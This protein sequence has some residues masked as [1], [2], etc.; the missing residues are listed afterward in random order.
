MN[1][2]ETTRLLTWSHVGLR[3]LYGI[4]MCILVVWSTFTLVPGFSTGLFHVSF[5][6]ATE[7][8]YLWICGMSL[9][10]GVAYV[11]NARLD[12]ERNIIMSGLC[13]FCAVLVIGKEITQ[14]VFASI[15]LSQN[16]SDLAVHYYWFL[17]IFVALQCLLILMNLGALLQFYWYRQHLRMFQ[18]I[19]RD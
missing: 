2:A 5:W 8:L 18:Q 7:I 1:P 17:V 14:V 10:F 16:T 11:K 15:E 3:A 6:L 12:F 13:M 9:G 19:K 4:Y